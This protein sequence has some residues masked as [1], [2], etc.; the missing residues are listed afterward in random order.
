MDP[1]GPDLEMQG[2]EASRSMGGLGKA[3]VFEGPWGGWGKS[4][5]QQSCMVYN[6]L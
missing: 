2:V 6:V 5:D 3:L 1:N 4:F